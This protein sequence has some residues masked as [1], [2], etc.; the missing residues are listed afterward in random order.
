M[1]NS[2]C[3]E[4]ICTCNNGTG[5]RGAECFGD[6]LT[7]CIKC[8]SGFRMYP[9]N[10][11]CIKIRTQSPTQAPTIS[12]TAPTGSPEYGIEKRVHCRNSIIDEKIVYPTLGAAQAAC[13]TKKECGGVYHKR[14]IG[15]PY[16]LCGSNYLKWVPSSFG[17]CVHRK[18]LCADSPM[19]WASKS[20][21]TCQDY[22]DHDFCTIDGT[23]GKNWKVEILGAI[24]DWA[25]KNGVDAFSACC[26]CGGGKREAFSP[27][28]Q[29]SVAISRTFCW[30]G[31]IF[32]L[33]ILAVDIL[34]W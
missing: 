25:N 1:E 34:S 3:M 31:V 19:N 2:L 15:P 14:C 24:S 11:V 16:F 21:H 7:K 23:Y 28:L 20:N 4:N 27:L 9:S 10:Y 13:N 30:H 26:N 29:R 32:V 18:L 17:S 5:A 33:L 12:T 8:D 6:G 22:K